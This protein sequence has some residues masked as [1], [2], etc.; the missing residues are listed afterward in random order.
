LPRSNGLLKRK[1]KERQLEVSS[2]QKA[3]GEKSEKGYQT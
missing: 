3:V 1:K 2:W